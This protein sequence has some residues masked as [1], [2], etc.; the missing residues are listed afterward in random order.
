MPLFTI[1]NQSSTYFLIL[2]C[3]TLLALCV[4]SLTNGFFWDTIQLGSKHANYFYQNDFS[5]LILPNDIDSGHIPAFGMYLGLIWKL[6][7]RDIIVSHLAMLP[8][9][10]GI[11]WQLSKLAKHYIGKDKYGLSVLLILI[12]PTL[13]SQMALISPDIV[14]VCFLIMSWNAII[15]NRKK[16][17]MLAILLLF[18]TSMR[19]IMVAFCLLFVD[20][21]YNVNFKNSFNTTIHSLIKRSVIYLPSLIVFISFSLY[22]YHM[23]GWIGFHDESTWADCFER[24][25]AKGLVFNLGILGW[26][27]IDFGRIGIWVIFGILFLKYRKHILK[28]KQTKYML[29]ILVC[30]II[31]LPANMIWAKNL[32]AHRYL[33]PIYLIFSILVANILFS[34][35]IQK[36]LRN[37]LISVWIMSLISGNFWIYPDKLSQGWDSTLAH[38]PYYKLRNNAISYIDQQ[39]IDIKNVHSFFPNLSVIDDMDLNNDYRRFKPYKHGAE[40]ILYSNIYNI[41]DEIYDTIHEKYD[42][43]KEYKSHSIFVHI[44]KKKED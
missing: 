39:Q 33:L 12:D 2:S 38:L 13:L 42:L 24:V 9:M 29:I 16:T 18:L 14:L 28:E 6:F 31:L 23:T 19:G 21:I 20:L 5:H 17:L 7:G 1:K 10:I 32:L 26:R 35:F 3:I 41:S 15:R 25:D 22:H 30:F 43:V 44:L 36:T 40:Y 37:V 4:V 27:I 8:F 34:S 11:I